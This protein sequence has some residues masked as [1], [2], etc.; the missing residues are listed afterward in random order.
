IAKG[1][2]EA[3]VVEDPYVM[4]VQVRRHP[5]GE[6]QPRQGALN[7]NAVEARQHT[8][9]LVRMPIKQRG[10]GSPRRSSPA[11]VRSVKLTS[12][13]LPARTT[14]Q[15]ISEPWRTLSLRQE[16][17]VTAERPALVLHASSKT[18]FGSG[19]SGPGGVATIG[20]VGGAAPSLAPGPA[21]L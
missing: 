20:S 2:R 9:D 16:A 12:P 8:E 14:A 1:F 6:A 10:H 13:D 15:A 11:C 19:S 7:D 4:R 17:D 21:G 18:L 5:L 3:R